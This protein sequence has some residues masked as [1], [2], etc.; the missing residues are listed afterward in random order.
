MRNHRPPREPDWQLIETVLAE[1]DAV[2]D[3]VPGRPT[4]AA[5][6]VGDHAPMVEHQRRVAVIL[7][8]GGPEL[9]PALRA[10]LMQLELSPRTRPRHALDVARV[11]SRHRVGVASLALAVLIAIAV[12]MITARSSAA[13]SAS[14]FAAVWTRPQT[15]APVAASESNPGELSVAFHG[16]PFPNYHDTEGWHPA[17]TRADQIAG[18]STLTVFYV[19]GRRRAA[20]TVV[21]D[22]GVSVPPGARHLVVNGMRLVE[23]RDGPV[24]V[25]VFRDHNNSCVLTAAAPR[26]KAWL[27]KLAVWSR[28]SSRSPHT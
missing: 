4:V 16:T 7:G 23:F 14:R 11:A 20:Y 2:R 26:E 13:A 1:V 27:V 19:I 6:A 3:V 25:I 10:R 15:G 22:T 17:G 18:R 12:P 28:G 5:A 8:G 21:A 9:P 24:W